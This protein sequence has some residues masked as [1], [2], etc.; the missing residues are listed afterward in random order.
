[1]TDWIK[2]R[3]YA[4]EAPF[5]GLWKFKLRIPGVHFKFE[6]ADYIQGLI[7]LKTAVEQKHKICKA[8]IL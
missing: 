7:I 6:W 8:C 2:R 5:I 4:Q 3:P 1:M